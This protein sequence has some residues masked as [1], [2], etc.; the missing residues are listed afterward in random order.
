MT[1]NRTRKGSVTESARK[2]YGTIGEKFPIFDKKSAKAAKQLIGRA[3]PKLT[4]AQRVK[5][6]AK[7]NRYLKG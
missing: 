5:V 1:V 4:A 7:A 3:K 6:T 2:N